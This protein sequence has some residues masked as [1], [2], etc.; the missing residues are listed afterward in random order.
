MPF[1]LSKGHDRSKRTNRPLVSLGS[2]Y[3]HLAIVAVPLLES[4]GAA[5]VSHFDGAEMF[6]EFP[7]ARSVITHLRPPGLSFAHPYGGLS[8]IGSCYNIGQN[9]L[10]SQEK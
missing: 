2:D 3:G 7:R 4:S 9:V 1:A 8:L 6:G 5:I 10:V